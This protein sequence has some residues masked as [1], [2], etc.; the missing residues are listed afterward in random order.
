[1][2]TGGPDNFQKA[3]Y[4]GWLTTLCQLKSSKT[5]STSQQ[6]IHNTPHGKPKIVKVQ[7]ASGE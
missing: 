5:R 4:V 7:S 1:M 6:E 3:V 2:E